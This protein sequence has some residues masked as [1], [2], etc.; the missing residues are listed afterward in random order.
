[1]LITQSNKYISQIKTISSSLPDKETTVMVTGATG[2][3]GSCLADAL[4]IANEFYNKRYKVVLVGR[5]EEKLRKR[6]S[7]ADH[8]SLVYVVQ[9]IMAPIHGDLNVDYIL[10]TASNADPVTYSNYPAETLLTNIYGTQNVLD[11]CRRHSKTRMLFTSTFEV[12]GLIDNQDVYREDD[13]GQIDLNQIRS[14]Y[15]ESKRCAEI[16]VRCY[17]K[18]H[19]IDGVIARLC[20]IYGP[21]MSSDDSKAHAQFI[22]NG[23]QGKDIVL[24]SL[25]E[26][27]RTYA[28]LVDAVSG[29]F[30]VLFKGKSGD[31]YNISNDKSVASIAEVA[32]TVAKICNTKVIYEPPSEIERA[33]FSRPQNCVLDNAKLRELGWEGKYNLYNGLM[34]TID[35][36]R[37]LSC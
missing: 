1:M 30:T 24:K 22:R 36:L 3:I 21:T 14:C 25:G 20:S 19:G 4:I 5:S 32:S 27:T 16:L 6:F 15:P 11:Y 13:S 7:Y 10:H 35:I 18:E 31:V 29:I 23:I 26:Q 8:N 9:D 33:G 17:Q 12:Y 28:Y 37:E 34:E 2:L